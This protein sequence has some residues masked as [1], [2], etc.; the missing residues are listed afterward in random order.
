MDTA[1][2]DFLILMI[3]S[4]IFQIFLAAHQFSM[5]SLEVELKEEDEE[6]VRELRVQ[7]F[8]LL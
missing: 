8:V 4:L 7:T 5:I 3:S 1:L 2:P 6:G